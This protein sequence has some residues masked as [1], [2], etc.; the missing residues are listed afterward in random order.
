MLVRGT[1]LVLNILI[2]IN[3][4]PLLPR[5]LSKDLLVHS[6]Q[7]TYVREVSKVQHPP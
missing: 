1:T 3:G 4:R 5:E 6:R 2:I 7:G